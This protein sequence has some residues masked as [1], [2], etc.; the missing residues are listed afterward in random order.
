MGNTTC[1]Q[2]AKK[3]RFGAEYNEAE[4]LF[5]ILLYFGGLGGIREAILDFN[6]VIFFSLPDF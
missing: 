6:H 4:I 2:L 5:E 1:A 3:H